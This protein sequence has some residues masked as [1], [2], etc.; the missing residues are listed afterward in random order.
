MKENIYIAILEYGEK[1]L[2]KAEKLS[3]EGLEGFLF[4]K[5]NYS[6]ILKYEA[7]R[8]FIESFQDIAGDQ[9]ADEYSEYNSISSKAYFRLVTYKQL[10]RSTY[11]LVFASI[12][13]LIALSALAISIKQMSN[14]IKIDSN[15]FKKV[16]K[17]I[18]NLKAKE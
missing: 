15:Q 18:D 6:K 17:S 12:S 3:W 7:K 1:K 8:F 2:K 4:T 13:V 9:K 11:A 16:L 5:Q 10:K 14:P